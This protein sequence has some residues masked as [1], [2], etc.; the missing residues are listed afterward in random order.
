VQIT[1]PVGKLF[2]E[3]KDIAKEFDVSLEELSRHKSSSRH[4]F[5]A[6]WV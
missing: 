5:A 3:F 4:V 2:G 1:D 6:L